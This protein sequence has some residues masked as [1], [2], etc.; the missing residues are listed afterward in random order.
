M[1]VCAPTIPPHPACPVFVPTSP[2]RGLYGRPEVRTCWVE[3]RT[4]VPTSPLRGLMVGPEDRTCW[5][6]GTGGEE[7]EMTL[8]RLGKWAVVVASSFRRRRR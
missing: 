3:V 5:A 8:R 2:L 6:E 7:H 1:R 4:F